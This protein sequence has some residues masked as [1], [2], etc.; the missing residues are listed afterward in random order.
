MQTTPYIENAVIMSQGDFSVIVEPK[1]FELFHIIPTFAMAS[2]EREFMLET[3]AS[4]D[5]E[6]IVARGAADTIIKTVRHLYQA[7]QD[8]FEDL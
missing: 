4:A 1:G 3:F 6:F 5:D 7:V 8:K 2:E